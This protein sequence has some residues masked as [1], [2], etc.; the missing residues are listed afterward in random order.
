MDERNKV[1]LEFSAIFLLLALLF[2]VFLFALTGGCVTSAKNTY[3][4]LMEQ[5]T[6]PISVSVPVVTD[7]PLEVT[8]EPT[9]AE[10][11][12]DWGACDPLQEC[13]KLREFK[14]YFRDNANNFGEDLRT[15]ITVYDYRILPSYHYYSVSWARNFKESPPDGKQY[16]FIFVN[17]YL[18]GETKSGQWVFPQ[19]HFVLQIRNNTYLPDDVDYPERRITE[20]DEI[21]N[22]GRTESMKPYGF[23]IVQEKGSGIITAE[24]LEWLMGGRSNAWDGYI[25]YQIPYGTNINETKVSASFANLG[26]N[27]FWKLD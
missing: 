3:K 10:P 21:Q 9:P 24:K 14:T 12:Y 4:G 7:T 5:P 18:D 23:K 2:L 13:Y 22:Y 19:N 15:S 26:G 20:F 25:I 27:V 16:L 11:V 1:F 8:P 17:M 6:T